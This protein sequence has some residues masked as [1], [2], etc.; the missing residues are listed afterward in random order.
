M[1]KPKALITSRTILTL[2][3]GLLSLILNISCLY[4]FLFSSL[5]FSILVYCGHAISNM[6]MFLVC[7]SS[8]IKS[9]LLD[10]VAFRKWYSKSHTIVA[11]EF[12]KTCPLFHF[13]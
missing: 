9:D 12:S 6:H 3:Q 11:W 13:S 2:N 7:F 8:S 10:V 1:L 4:F 5:F